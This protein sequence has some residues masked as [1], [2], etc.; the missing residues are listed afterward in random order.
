MKYK[1]IKDRDQALKSL[2]VFE[3]DRYL[4][5]DTEVAVK[6]FSDIDFFNDK[7]R[8]IQIGNEEEIYVYDMFELSD[9]S[10]RLKEILENKGIIGHNLKFDI[11]FLISNFNIFPKTV[12]DTMIASQLISGDQNERH[13]LSAVSYRLTDS[14]IDKSYQKSPW[15]MRN[16]SEE[17][18]RYAAKDVQVLREIFPLLKDELNKLKSPHKATGKIYETFGLK[19]GVAVVEMAF[20]PLLAEIELRGMPIDVEKLGKMLSDMSSR[21]QR[22][23]IE[24]VRKYGVDPFSPQKVT[25]WLTSKLKLKLPKT[26]KG[27][28]SSQDSA[29]RKYSDREEIKKLISIR[30]DKKLL[31]KLKELKS[32]TINGRIH[33]EFKQIG[34]PTGRMSSIRPNLQNITRDLR[35]LF[36]PPEDKKLI[37]ADYSQIELRIAAEYVNEETMINAFSEKRDLHKFTASL[38]LNKKYEEIDKDERQMAKAI[39]FGLIYGISP[40]SLME[41]ARNSYGVDISLKEAQIFHSKFFEVYKGFKDWHDK[42]KEV[43]N[44]KGKVTVYSLLGRRM[45]VRKFTEA[46]NF[47]I[48]GTGSDLLKMAVVFFGKLKGNLNGG[49]VN[50]VHDE[51]VVEADKNNVDEIKNILSESME[52]AGKILLKKVPVEFDVSIVENWG[53]K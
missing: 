35:V 43:L 50:L 46:V 42:V 31:D 37:V 1:Y 21:Y 22:E 24:F 19:N 17:Q 38:I 32:H 49:I 7:V 41:Y 15:G 47:P 27:S 30:S 3:E 34:A 9:I 26:E 45:V 40:K 28:L 39:N 13:S 52:K 53:E 16:L 6:S 36:K 11:K 8:L 25:H 2:E 44:S 12:F 18:I 51:I 29:L 10:D 23:Y 33:S 14:R 20:V 4:Y 5:L 48:Q